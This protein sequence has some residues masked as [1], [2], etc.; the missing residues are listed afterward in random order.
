MRKSIVGVVTTSRAV[1]L[2][3]VYPSVISVAG[4]FCVVSGR[5][6]MLD[7]G[8]FITDSSD[9]LILVV[10]EAVD[11]SIDLVCA[12]CFVVCRFSHVM[13]AT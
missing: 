2:R 5:D 6:V 13:F 11:V 12:F 4:S 10:V 3:L 8:M 9:V 1:R 7:I